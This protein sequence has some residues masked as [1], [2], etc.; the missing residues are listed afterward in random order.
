[1]R[2]SDGKY[3]KFAKSQQDALDSYSAGLGY[4]RGL[5]L[6]AAIKE[7]KDSHLE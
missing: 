7:I 4:E 1:M 6:S 2:K 5:A 3:K